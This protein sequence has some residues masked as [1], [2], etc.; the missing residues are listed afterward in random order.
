MFL[1]DFSSSVQ[2]TQGGSREIRKKAIVIILLRYNLVCRGDEKWLDSVCI[3][4]LKL[5]E[6]VFLLEFEGNR[7]VKNVSRFLVR[8]IEGCSYE[9]VTTVGAVR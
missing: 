3:V 4:K 9:V 2:S 6:F 8:E 1:K 7:K 5:R